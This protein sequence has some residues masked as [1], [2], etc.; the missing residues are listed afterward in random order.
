M[1]TIISCTNRPNSNTLKDSKYYLQLLEK[2]GVTTKLLSLEQLPA[3][4]TATDLY[5]K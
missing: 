3:D 2:Q 1:I 5:V 4:F